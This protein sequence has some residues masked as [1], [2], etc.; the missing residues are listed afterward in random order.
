MGD[1][2]ESWVG[3]FLIVAGAFVV[4]KVLSKV[5][6]LTHKNADIVAKLMATVVGVT[7]IAMIEPQRSLGAVLD[8]LARYGFGAVVGLVSWVF[9]LV[10]IGWALGDDE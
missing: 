2:G 1:S 7:Y 8:F 9:I 5:G 4:A 10:G 3:A 6:V